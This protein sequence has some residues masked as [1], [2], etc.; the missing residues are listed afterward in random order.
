MSGRHSP[1]YLSNKLFSPLFRYLAFVAKPSVSIPSIGGFGQVFTSYLFTKYSNSTGKVATTSSAQHL[2]LIAR[3]GCPV[4]G[5][6]LDLNTLP[7][8]AA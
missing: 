2:Q 5:G 3:P 8:L 1:P 7:S 6:L 4:G